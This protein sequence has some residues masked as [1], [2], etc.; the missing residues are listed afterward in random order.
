MRVRKSREATL[1][2][3][4]R[5]VS[6]P[7]PDCPLAYISRRRKSYKKIHDN[8]GK[9]VQKLAKE[10][11]KKWKADPH[12]PEL[13]FKPLTDM[14]DLWSVRVGIHQ[15]VHYRAVAIK[16]DPYVIWIWIGTREQFT[17]AAKKKFGT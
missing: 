5:I 14:G 11:Y 2:T 12:A 13:H 8:L 7:L 10:A 17:S 16:E 1:R 4:R 15:G 6:R 3:R 9:E